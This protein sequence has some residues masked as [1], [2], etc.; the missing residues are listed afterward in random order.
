MP[1][2]ARVGATVRV[3]NPTGYREE[4]R[5]AGFRPDRIIEVERSRRNGDE[6]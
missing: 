6:S 2:E 5:G 4:G 1:H 3:G